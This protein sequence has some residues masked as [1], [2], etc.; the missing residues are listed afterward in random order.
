MP[1]KSTNATAVPSEV[2]VVWSAEGP[3]SVHATEDAAEIALNSSKPNSYIEQLV[4]NGGTV[5]VDVVSKQASTT[6]AQSKKADTV[7]KEAKDDGKGPANKTKTAA[8]QRADNA[9]KVGKPD[10]ADLPANVK[11]LLQKGGSVFAGQTVVVTGVPPTLGRKDTEKLVE[12]FGAH[13]GKSLSKK[14]GYVVIGN[15]A[16]PKKYVVLASSKC[17]VS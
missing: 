16:G 12:A 7:K 6:N 1:S 3:E 15:E 11:K 5:N 17:L 10:D 2:Y 4:L 9:N 13:L 14:T 8:Q